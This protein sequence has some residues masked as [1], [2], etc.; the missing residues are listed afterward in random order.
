MGLSDNLS[1]LDPLGIRGV[2]VQ[3]GGAPGGR[4]R[5][6][7]S[8]LPSESIFRQLSLLCPSSLCISTSAFPIDH[9]TGVGRLGCLSYCFLLLLSWPL[10]PCTPKAHGFWG[11]SLLCI[12]LLKLTH[13]SIISVLLCSPAFLQ[14]YSS[15]VQDLGWGSAHPS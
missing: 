14:T 6:Q 15:L 9:S 12:C 13:W 2:H 7:Q 5:Q 1:R 8:F 10:P 11:T 3:A 4:S